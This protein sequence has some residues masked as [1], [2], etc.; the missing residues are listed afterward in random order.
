MRRRDVSSFPFSSNWPLRTG[1]EC[2]EVPQ[3]G[4]ES[5]LGL[6]FND[7]SPSSKFVHKFDLNWK[8]A[9]GLAHGIDCERSTARRPATGPNCAVNLLSGLLPMFRF[10]VGSAT[11]EGDHV[12][13]LHGYSSRNRRRKRRG[14]TPRASATSQNSITSSRRSP[15]SYFET[16]DCGRSSFAD[17]SAW[18]SPAFLRVSTRR[19]RNRLYES[20]PNDQV[21]WEG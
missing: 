17:S 9:I 1:Q 3:P 6:S 19:A 20:F 10:G 12:Y 11:L 2:I 7:P 16:N 5:V 8:N 13:D 14:S 18:V 15:R 4:I 21:R